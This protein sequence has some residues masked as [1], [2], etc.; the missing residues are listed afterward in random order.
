MPRRIPESRLADLLDCATAVFIAQ[1]YRQT[2]MSDVA[3]ALGVAKGTVY[4][5]VES[6][7]ALFAAALLY[8]DTKPPSPSEVELPIPTL[9]PG[10]LAAVVRRRLARGIVPPALA[11]AMERKR[12][13]DVRAGHLQQRYHPD[14][15]RPI[16]L[17]PYA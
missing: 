3:E 8:A 5:S 13:R 7:E 14:L 2:Q 1:G 6:K 16:P 17:R 12:V 9:P 10:E 4:L 15:L 11:R